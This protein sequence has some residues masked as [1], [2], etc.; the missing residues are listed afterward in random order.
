VNTENARK[1]AALLGTV[2]AGRTA[3]Q[4]IRQAR[5]ES[6]RLEMLDALFNVLVVITGVL[7]IVRRLREGDEEL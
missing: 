4:R 7:V 1:I 3:I 6:D 2:F 5:A